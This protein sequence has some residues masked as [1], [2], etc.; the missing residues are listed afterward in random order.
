[1]GVLRNTKHEMVAQA[2]AIGATTAEASHAAGIRAGS[3]FKSNAKKRAQRKDIKARVVELM[4]IDVCPRLG[5]ARRATC[6]S[7]LT[8]VPT[9]R[10]YVP[11]CVAP[12]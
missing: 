5:L 8:T 12:A 1:M 6:A 2:L 9:R 4:E 11:I 10:N 7:A 3:S